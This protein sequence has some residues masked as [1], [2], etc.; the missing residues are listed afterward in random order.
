MYLFCVYIY[1]YIYGRNRTKKVENLQ[2]VSRC[3]S[4]SGKINTFTGEQ[5]SKKFLLREKGTVDSAC[6]A[7]TL[8]DSEMH[9]EA[10]PR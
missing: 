5:I 2:V 6:S 9:L 7:E 1:I 10:F 3:P 4:F 8:D